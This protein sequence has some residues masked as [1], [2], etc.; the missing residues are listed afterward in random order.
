MTEFGKSIRI[1]LKDGS[2]TGIKFG[3]VVNQTIQSVSCPRKRIKELSNYPES[4]RPGIYF[5]FGLDDNTGNMQAYIGEAENVFER[6]QNHAINKDFWSE[7]I[8]FVSKDENLTK[9][10]VKYL[11]SRTVQIANKI[12]RYKIENGNIPQTAALP[13][14]DRDAMEEFLIYIKLLIG[15]LGHK[16]LEEVTSTK[17]IPI[18]TNTQSNVFNTTNANLELFFN[19]K[20]LK[21]YGLLT[22]EGLVVLDN[23]EASFI[24]TS[25]LQIG[26]RE[27]RESL[28]NDGTLKKVGEKLIFQK[29]QLFYSP[30]AAACVIAGTSRNGRDDW[31]DITG[32]S[33]NEIE[34]K[35]LK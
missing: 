10:H 14:A 26:Y 30:S 2:V 4:Q 35:N 5:L 31:K 19:A 12:K 33:L 13:P 22:D 17:S 3:E 16:L 24:Q 15:I 9:S 7:V 25:K 28:I 6:L 11:E 21:A 27:L 32:L 20:N 29:N 8:F 23:S 1:Y 18:T 34:K